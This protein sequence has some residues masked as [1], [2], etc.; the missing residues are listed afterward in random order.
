MQNNHKHKPYLA[1]M[2]LMCC[3]TPSTSLNNTKLRASSFFVSVTLTFVLIP[4]SAAI[5]LQRLR[6]YFIIVRMCGSVILNNKLMIIT[7]IMI[8][9]ITIIIIIIII[10]KQNTHKTHHINT[11]THTLTS[12]SHHT[13]T[14]THTH[15]HTY[16]Q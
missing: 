4:I 11:H 8:I 7:I 6:K 12:T 1:S 13:Q 15:T 2:T 14:H 3:N 5:T 16:T 9:I 10:L